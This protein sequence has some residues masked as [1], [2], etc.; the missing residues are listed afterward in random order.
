MGL[1]A[2][3]FLVIL[4]TIS[5][6]ALRAQNPI[7]FSTPPDSNVIAS[8]LH[9]GDPRLVAWGASFTLRSQDTARIPDL[10]VLARDWRP[11]A[12]EN[13]YTSNDRA[14]AMSVVLDTLIQMQATVPAESIEG[15]VHNFPEPALILLSRLPWQEGQPVLFKFY[16]GKEPGDYG[17]LLPHIAAALLALHPPPGFAVNLLSQVMLHATLIVT[18]IRAADNGTSSASAR[19]C[20]LFPPVPITPNWPPIYNYDLT[21]SAPAPG[22]QSDGFIVVPGSPAIRAVRS[23]DR[24]SH[25]CFLEY[26]D[27]SRIRLLAQM[28]GQPIAP[29]V[30]V[31]MNHDNCRCTT[32]VPA[33]PNDPLLQMLSTNHA[34]EYKDAPQFLHDVQEYITDLQAKF[35]VLTTNLQQKGALTPEESAGATPHINIEVVDRRGVTPSALP[36]LNFSDSHIHIGRN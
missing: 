16:W 8:W 31:Q 22:A 9:S 21:D 28:A 32:L 33:P 25:S 14:R 5:A 20:G 18:P 29:T 12:V 24:Y 15:L 34:V 6:A 19:E 10:V 2:R 30:M 13:S 11:A 26:T 1:N 7:D 4:L 27:E 23:A 35:R 3:S 36:T 17:D